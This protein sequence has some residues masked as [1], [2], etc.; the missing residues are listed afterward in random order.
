MRGRTILL[1]LFCFFQSGC[2][3]SYILSR[4]T[5]DNEKIQIPIIVW[6]LGIVKDVRVYEHLP[7]EIKNTP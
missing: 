5:Y 3:Q 4:A 7:E 2:M 6:I 1:S